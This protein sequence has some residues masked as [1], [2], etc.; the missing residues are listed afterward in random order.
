LTIQ[1]AAFD[2]ALQNIL[3]NINFARFGTNLAYGFTNVDHVA[4]A[5]EHVG[6]ILAAPALSEY[7]P[8]LN[9]SAAQQQ[10]GIN[11]AEYEWVP[12]QMMGLVRASS[13]PRYVVYAYGQSLRPAPNG[14]DTSSTY[15]GLVTNYQVVAESAVR[16]VISVQSKVDMSG[17]YPVTNYTTHVES[18]NVLPAD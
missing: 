14:L 5:F 17:A 18:Y 1:P 16:A 2:V 12:Q 6:D 9:V 11:D 15:F 10:Y 4:G 3:T 13:T 8:F 7:S